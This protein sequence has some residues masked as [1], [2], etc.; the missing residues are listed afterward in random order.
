MSQFINVQ[1]QHRG[2]NPSTTQQ[3]NLLFLEAHHVW[4][5][6]RVSL[7]NEKRGTRT[8][9]M[10]RAR[11]AL[12]KTHQR[13]QHMFSSVVNATTPQLFFSA[14]APYK[15][16]ARHPDRSLRCCESHGHYVR[17][18]TVPSHV[19]SQSWTDNSPEYPLYLSILLLDK[20]QLSFSLHPRF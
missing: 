9:F 15:G 14:N 17:P 2:Q 7:P 18:V 6:P 8:P 19:T 10:L 16:E 3:K 1:S 4:Q 5:S 11:R 12:R 13:P 20:H